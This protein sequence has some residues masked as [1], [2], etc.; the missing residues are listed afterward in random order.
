MTEEVIELSITETQALRAKLG[1]SPLRGVATSAPA[2]AKEN[3]KG[4]IVLSI[5]ETNALRAKIGLPP[6]TTQTTNGN[7]TTGSSKTNAIHAP[8]INL[9]ATNETKRRIEDAAAK[10]DSASRIQLLENENKQHKDKGG[11]ESALDFAAKMMMKKKGDEGSCS[12]ED[13]GV[14]KQGG[15]TTTT[16]KKKRKKKKKRMVNNP[17]LSL[18]NNDDEDEED[19]SN[20]NNNEPTSS[21][22]SADLKGLKVSHAASDFT[23]GTTTVL[24]LADKSILSV[25]SNSNKV[26]GLLGSD[27][28]NNEDSELINANIDSDT[29][30]LQNLR[31]KRAIELGA[32]RA[33][34]YA[35]YDDEEFEEL[36]GVGIGIGG[37]NN[38]NDGPLAR[39]TKNG[40]GGRTSKE[41]F[42][43]GTDGITHDNIKGKERSSDLFTTF[44]GGAI[45]LNS[46][47]NPSKVAS[48]FMTHD[49]NDDVDMMGGGKVSR[50]EKLEKE[51][52]KQQKILEKL[53]KKDKKKKAKKKRRRRDNND[54]E[55]DDDDAQ[56]GDG[57]GGVSLLA[58]LEATAVG[59]NNNLNAKRK[60]Q[61]QADN[62]DD[63]D[64][65]NIDDN[66]GKIDVG[67]EDD[68]TQ[69]RKRFDTIMAKGKERTD[70]AFNK[71]KPIP[72]SSKSSIMED[73]GND[74]DD[75]D[76]FLNAALAKARRLKRLK[77][78]SSGS[79]NANANGNMGMR[80]KREDAVVKA[81]AKMKQEEEA[82]KD[83]EAVSSGGDAGITFEFDEMQEFTRALRARE[84]QVKRNSEKKGDRSRRGVTIS[85]GRSSGKKDES[86]AATTSI[87]TIPV[88]EE[89]Q[90]NVQVEDVDMDELAQEMKDN[91]DDDEVNVDGEDNTTTE[92]GGF[93]ATAES[94]PIGRGMSNFLSLLQHTGEIKKHATKEEMRGRA[95]DK[96]TYEDYE[97]LD[98]QKVVN[99][100]T[101]RSKAHEKDI[102]FANREIKL[103][104]RDDFGR[105][106]TRKEA[107]RNMCYQFHGHGSS[108]K[109]QERRL[110]QIERE[111][112]EATLA[113]RGANTTLGALKAT[114]KA[115]GKSYIVH[116]T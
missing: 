103:E 116:K 68:M 7:D 45:N 9:Q 77:E 107:Y 63:E 55:S 100:D 1:L 86:S 46:R 22:T 52:K 89:N 10:R 93:G 27:N 39:G 70:R 105:L 101:N 40:G 53:R 106:L 96:R 21:Y 12:T 102:E 11:D 78:L 60:R 97:Q 47:N 2:L 110:K 49:D 108:K 51:R 43:I 99:V 104:Y 31:K 13:V 57:G 33:G 109:N 67:E 30:A 29:Q 73:D 98:L 91:I 36:G 48:D 87:A 6:L 62:I 115:T 92:K 94:A 58:N 26:T 95:K 24:T 90:D 74:D 82:K 35:G 23:A 80:I 112:E 28:G 38:S 16:T 84:D 113:S 25:D 61:R 71:K 85:S 75:D 44:S 20:N 5:T 18:P 111:R 66:S 64:I 42:E 54:D 76:A 72:I 79:S 34:G 41:G 56:E 32:G 81:V 3:D 114:Q 17:Q 65:M 14:D 15:T 88:K 69:K 83:G 19:T 4:E 8:P 37:I 59:N 50:E